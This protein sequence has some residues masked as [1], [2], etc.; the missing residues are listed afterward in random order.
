MLRFVDARMYFR[1]SIAARALCLMLLATCTTAYPQTEASAIE[2]V[3]AP[4]A[5]AEAEP[6]KDTTADELARLGDRVAGF[7][8]EI[9]ALEA[10][11]DPAVQPPAPTPRLDYL[12]R[13]KLLAQR[14]ISALTRAQ[15][16]RELLA[17][18]P[19]EE[20]VAES[21]QTKP[22]RGGASKA[23]EE[24]PQPEPVDIKSF[25]S[26]LDQIDAAQ[27]HITAMQS[28]LQS[29]KEA[30]K[31]A[32]QFH[33]EASSARRAA[34]DA[35]AKAVAAGG[36]GPEFEALEAAR[37]A[38]SLAEAQVKVEEALSVVAELELQLAE[39]SLVEARAKVAEA[40]TRLVF[41]EEALTAI[42]GELTGKRES[43]SKELNKLYQ[44]RGKLGDQ[45]FRAREN[46]AKASPETAELMKERLST[47]ETELSAANTGIQN[48][49][50]RIA[51]LAMEEESWKTR[52]ALMNDAF[53]GSVVDLIRSNSAKLEVL[54]DSIGQVESRS[55]NNLTVRRDIER[56]LE[57]PDLNADLRSTLQRRAAALDQVEGY[58]REYT[59]DLVR[60]EKL[61]R[62]IDWS[63]NQLLESQGFFA[64]LAEARRIATL[65]WN[66][67]L[68]V[69][70]DRGFTVAPLLYALLAYASMLS[71]L[72]YIRRT[73]RK[74]LVK[75]LAKRAGANNAALRDA[76]LT[77]INGAS[78][79]VMVV[80]SI[81]PTLQFLPLSETMRTALTTVIYLSLLYQTALY[82]TN[83]MERTLNRHK[84]QRMKEDPSS[85]SAYGVMSF[86]ARIAIWTVL[87]LFALHSFDV[88]I[89]AAVATLGVGGIA[90]AFAL[91]SILADILSS[92]AIL[93]DK[94]F[95]V[96]DFV[97][98]GEQAGEVES[99]G[100]KTTRIKSLSGEQIVMSNTDLLGSRVHNFKRMQERRAVFQIGVT[101]QTTPEQLEAIPTVLREAVE[102][103]ELTRFDRAHFASFG[104]SALIFE[105]VYYV[106]SNDYKIFMDIQQAVNL[107][108]MRAFTAMG[109]EF[110][111][112]TQTLYVQLAGAPGPAMQFTVRE[113][114]DMP[115]AEPK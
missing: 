51:N 63:A 9:A 102:A 42:I 108:L 69:F 76:G 33:S 6:P 30:A 48:L 88:D 14:R 66:Y 97:K 90:V 1:P 94:P 46:A 15:Q 98:V 109:I 47:A 16:L 28:S 99:I 61:L 73:L 56:R 36:G 80:V 59:A 25:D 64:Q 68:F 92:V 89:T 45:L 8:E 111:Y 96:G 71:A 101:Y 107:Q 13:A 34:E 115:A 11:I 27:N 31:R 29:Q 67:E 83:W 75:F 41:D 112:P 103:N 53:V 19:A 23:E 18:P 2:N 93:L 84:M 86:F 5:A 10:A 55:R 113:S 58:D 32:A 21:T 95:A 50:E 81:W 60:Q 39:R 114:N 38:E 77:F 12:R 24:I 22:S 3:G 106:L 85:V 49:E 100:L 78:T 43:L 4:A 44:E 54:R 110:A 74:R 70:E 104:D 17:P 72:L 40:A 57:A 105:C 7:D 26:L 35:H 52:L 65:I 62:R 20:P 79:L 37:Y 87:V 82:A 91:Q